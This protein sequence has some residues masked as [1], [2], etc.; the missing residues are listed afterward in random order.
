MFN[1]SDLSS[2]K[3][4]QPINSSDGLDDIKYLLS[5]YFSHNA[6]ISDVILS[7]LSL[8]TSSY[9][10]KKIIY[11]PSFILYSKYSSLSS[12]PLSYNDLYIASYI[13]ISFKSYILKLLNS[14]NTGIKVVSSMVFKNKC[15]NNIDFPIPPVP[16]IINLFP[17]ANKLL[18][19]PVS[20]VLPLKRT[21]IHM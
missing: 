7:V 18:I 16:V 1:S 11:A 9:P 8:L 15:L 21:P 17:R 19:F 5:L 20:I 3:S 12:N 14:S 4:F 6:L 2:L 10:S 13:E